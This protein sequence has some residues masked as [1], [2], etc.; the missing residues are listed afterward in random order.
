MA[1][2]DVS[3]A[4]QNRVGSALKSP[5]NVVWRYG[6][7]A[8]DAN[9]PNIGRVFKPAHTCQVGCAI[10]AP[11]THKSDYLGLKNILIHLSLLL[12]GLNAQRAFYLGVELIVIKSHKGRSL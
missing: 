5:Q 7:R 2:A 8:H 10:C 6:G 3:P 1:V 12:I 4:H 11:V 9:G